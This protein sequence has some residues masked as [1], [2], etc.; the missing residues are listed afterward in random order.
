MLREPVDAAGL[1][2]LRRLLGL[3]LAV[4]IARFALNGW[5]DALLVRPA[6]HFHY[7]GFGWWPELSAPWVYVAFGVSFLA[8]VVLALGT[9]PRVA[10]GTFCVAFTG[11]ELI[12]QT[13]YLNHY[14]L[15][16]LLTGLL[17][18]L[19]AETRVP[20]WIYW[21]LRVQVGVVY[22][23]AGV[24]K[25]NADWLLR[26]EPLTTWLATFAD[27]PL[28]G[29][30]FESRPTA[31]AMSWVGA[32]FDLTIAGWL[33]WPKTR[34][35]AYIALLLFHALIWLLFPVGIFSW[36]MVVAATAFFEPGWPR[37]WVARVVL[38][39]R[40]FPRPEPAAAMTP[41]ADPQSRAWAQVGSAFLLVHLALQV[42]LPLR[43]LLYPGDV[44]WTNEGFRFA[45]R[46]MLVEKVGHVEFIVKDGE[47][48]ERVFPERE[49]TRLQYAQMSVQPDMIQQY[50]LHLAERYRAER[51]HDVNVYADAWASLNGRPAARLIEPEVDLAHTRVSLAPATWIVPLHR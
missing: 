40:W 2:A 47:A 43:H 13:L 12:D 51:G 22:F 25:L 29:D 41:L 10:A 31:Y 35:L 1:N 16:S 21:A 8:A 19:P 23:Y 4:A 46:V 37:R 30:L 49:L 6:F 17:A 11:C 26:A 5:I 32:F 18:L 3:V 9:W 42:L 7:F 27:L 24:A 15:V 34:A 50:A 28:V 38:L 45:W 48:N 14:Y 44:N 33:V 20:R 36:V 39:Q